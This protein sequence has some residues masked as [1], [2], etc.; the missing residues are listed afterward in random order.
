MS[1][2]AAVL[3]APHDVRIEE[4]PMPQPGPK[5]VLLTGIFRYANTYQDAI[6]LVAAGRIDLKSI[7]T[8]YYTLEQTEQA[9]QAT[10]NDPNNI[11][12]VVVPGRTES[13]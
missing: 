1:N 5:E 12:S 7:I 10:R 13:K 2:Q 9:L 8:G 6:A 4:R 3:Y 11:K